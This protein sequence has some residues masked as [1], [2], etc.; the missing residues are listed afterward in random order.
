MI[1]ISTVPEN[2]QGSLKLHY[3][4]LPPNKNLI[5]LGNYLHPI[6]GGFLCATRAHFLPK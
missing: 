3:A 4:T 1:N 6:Q 5:K 2:R